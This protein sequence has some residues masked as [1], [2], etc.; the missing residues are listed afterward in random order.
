MIG[1]ANVRGADGPPFD[2]PQ[3]LAAAV[4]GYP[5][6]LTVEVWGGNTLDRSINGTLRKVW[7][8][9]R[10]CSLLRI[11]V[12]LLAGKP[13]WPLAS[14]AHQASRVLTPFDGAAC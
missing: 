7:S 1:E 10:A 13:V 3:W 4:P 11:L 8:G 12:L 2:F 9:L 14:F 5:L 6:P